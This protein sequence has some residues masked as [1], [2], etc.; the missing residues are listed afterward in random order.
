[1]SEET[2]DIQGWK[3]KDEISIS[4]QRDGFTVVFHRK[5]KECGKVNEGRMFVPRENVVSL[6]KIIDDN[7][8]LREDYKYRY[9][10]N[11][12]LQ[13]GVDVSAVVPEYAVIESRIKGMSDDVKKEFYSFA[14]AMFVAAFNGGLKFRSKLYFPLLYYPLKV[15]ESKGFIV[16]FGKGGIQ[17]IR[18]GEFK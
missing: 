1:M 7:C 13:K 14:S 17:K 10:V 6:W 8:E 3:G 16:Y 2:I 4:E 9:F 11:K 5:E 18:E 15:L 12:L